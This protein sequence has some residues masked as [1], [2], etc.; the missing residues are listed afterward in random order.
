M[1]K[2]EAL[3]LALEALEKSKTALAEELAAYDIDPPIYHLAEAHVLCEQ[4]IT[5]IKEALAQPEQGESEP[6]QFINAMKFDLVAQQH[7]DALRQ[8]G[9]A[10]METVKDKLA[11]TLYKEYGGK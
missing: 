9:R 11:E 3:K 6:D 10:T 4:S 2:D 7:L 1:T 8:A 5:A